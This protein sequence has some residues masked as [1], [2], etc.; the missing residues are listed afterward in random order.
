MIDPRAWAGERLARLLERLDWSQADMAMVLRMPRRHGARRISGVVNGRELAPVEVCAV[1]EA[2]ERMLDAIDAD[3]MGRLHWP[4][5]GAPLRYP[6]S[7]ADGDS[8]DGEDA[9]GETCD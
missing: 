3:P 4:R 8:P 5:S 6:L 2:L 9:A 1:W 7:D